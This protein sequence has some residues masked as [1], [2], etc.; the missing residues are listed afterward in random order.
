MSVSSCAQCA[1]LT[2]SV[3]QGMFKALADAKGRM[4]YRAVVKKEVDALVVPFPF[5]SASEEALIH[6][7]QQERH[8]WRRK[9]GA[10][11]HPSGCERRSAC[12]HY[13]KLLPMYLS[14][15]TDHLEF[16]HLD[17]AHQSKD[18]TSPDHH[19]PV[20]E[21]PRAKTACEGSEV[22]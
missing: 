2:G 1:A 20:P 10:W 17:K 16:R 7:I 13:C 14:L 8:V 19:R 18:R 12:V 5:R 22:R 21:I 3:S 11:T 15:L 9:Y 4:M 6:S